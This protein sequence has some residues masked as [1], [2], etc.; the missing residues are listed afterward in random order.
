M[1]DPSDLIKDGAL[2]RE[3]ER[4]SEAI[5]PQS[6][7]PR[8]GYGAEGY[9]EGNGYSRLQEY[10]RCV[11][12]HIW[13]ITGIIALMTTLSAIYMAGQPD[14]YESLARVQVDLEINNQ[15]LGASKSNSVILNTPYQDPTYFNTQL[16][17]LSSSGLLSRV[18]KTLDLEH[19]QA[20]LHP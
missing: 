7:V 17:I 9:D 5:A 15:V 12:K 18:I 10:W 11:R 14:I 6:Y 2:V 4:P 1:K 8:Y 20:F 3:Q 16:Q 13:L 19:N